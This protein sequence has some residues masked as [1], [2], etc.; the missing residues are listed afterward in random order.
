MLE[1]SGCSTG[2][3]QVKHEKINTYHPFSIYLI[4]YMYSCIRIVNLYFHRNKILYQ[5]EYRVYVQCLSL[6]LK[7]L[8]IVEIPWSAPF[9]S[10]LFTK[11]VSCICIT[12]SLSG[13]ILHSF[14][15]SLKLL[16]DF[17]LYMLKLTLWAMKFY[18]LFQ[19]HQVLYPPYSAFGMVSW[20]F[21][22][23]WFSYWGFHP[24]SISRVI[25]SFFCCLYSIASSKMSCHWNH[26]AFLN[27]LLKITCSKRHLRLICLFLIVHL[28]LLLGNLALYKCTTIC[29]FTYWQHFGCS[30][31]WA[32]IN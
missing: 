30:L 21:K 1:S 16:F 31:I 32:I 18:E 2:N 9:I 8:L 3:S 5:L 28:P 12:V 11:D 13:H 4:V 19:K 14:P 10:T 27:W 22:F 25:T 20:P 23:L 26:I 17:Y 29:T 6:V 24:P 15:G 7:T